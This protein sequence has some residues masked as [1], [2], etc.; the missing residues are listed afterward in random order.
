[1]KLLSNSDDSWHPPSINE[2][3]HDISS[4]QID[5]Q[6]LQPDSCPPTSCKFYSNLQPIPETSVLM[7]SN[8]QI[9]RQVTLSYTKISKETKNDLI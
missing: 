9:H 1:M 4:N 6:Y 5:T 2:V 7:H 3:T 8:L